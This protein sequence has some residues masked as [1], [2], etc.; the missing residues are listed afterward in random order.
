MWRLCKYWIGQILKSALM[1]ADKIVGVGVWER[2]NK[3]TNRENN[4][5]V[6]C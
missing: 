1:E 6:E 5:W 3:K 4:N 2:D